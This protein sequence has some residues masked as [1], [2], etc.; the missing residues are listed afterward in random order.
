MISPEHLDAAIPEARI[1]LSASTFFFVDLK[2]LDGVF[3][4]LL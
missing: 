4:L 1:M 3:S 2:R